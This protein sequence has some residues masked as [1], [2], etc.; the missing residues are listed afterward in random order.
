MVAPPAPGDSTAVPVTPVNA[1]SLG[2]GWNHFMVCVNRR[3]G[4]P[5]CAGAAIAEALETELRQRHLAIPVERAVCLGACDQGPNV[6][7]APGGRFYHQVTVAA[8]A[9]LVED[10][11][12]LAGK[13]ATR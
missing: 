3:I 8:V 2:T 12:K 10:A 7:L 6:R 11:C 4:K 1:D 5:A 13:P 9:E